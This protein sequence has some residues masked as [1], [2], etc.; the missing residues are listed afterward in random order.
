VKLKRR[1]GARLGD[2][3]PPLID[4]EL[5]VVLSLFSQLTVAPTETVMGL[6]EYAVLD[7][8]EAPFTIVTVVLPAGAGSGVGEGDEELLPPHAL[9]QRAAK[10]TAINLQNMVRS[11]LRGWKGKDAVTLIGCIRPIVSRSRLTG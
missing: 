2:A 1:P 9:R 11:L 10:K 7:S 4:V 3:H 8:I 5:C 6:G